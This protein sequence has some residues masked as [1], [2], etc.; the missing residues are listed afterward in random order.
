MA[1]TL[2]LR[3]ML[4]GIVA[5]L[6]CFSFLKIVGEPQVDQAIAFETQLDETKARAEAQAL[7]A[8]GLPVPKEEPEPELVSRRVQAGI[9]LFTGVMVYNVAFGGLFALAFG[10]AYGRMG[11]FDPRT[12]AALLAVF[13]VI[14]AYIVPNLKYPANPPAVGDPATIGMRTALYFSMIAISLAAMIAAGM[15]RLRLLARHC[16]WNAFL[17]AAGAYL[18]VVVVV[19]LGLP[20][21]NEVPAGFPAVVLWRFRIASAGAQLIMWTTTGLLFGVLAERVLALPAGVVRHSG[22]DSSRRAERYGEG[23]AERS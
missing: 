4:I 6:L 11:D 7:I 9:G 19:A 8:R 21:V 5:G 12:T 16:P 10:L 20:P 22:A 15:L 14:A 23:P 2:L 18:I 13:G 3:G 17:I 1:G